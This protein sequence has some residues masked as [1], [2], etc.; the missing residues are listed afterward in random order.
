VAGIDSVLIY[1]TLLFIVGKQHCVIAKHSIC[2]VNSETIMRVQSVNSTY[3]SNTATFSLEKVRE[4]L[5][6]QRTR[7]ARPEIYWSYSNVHDY[8]L[9][10]V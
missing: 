3:P 10:V 8:S 2:A 1:R 5:A 7:I 6:K 4:E 9:S